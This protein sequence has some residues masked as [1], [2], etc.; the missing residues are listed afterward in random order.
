MSARHRGSDMTK[1]S[2]SVFFALGLLA[3][4]FPATRAAGGADAG[5]LCDRFP[6]TLA[7][8][9]KTEALGPLFYS[10]IEDTRRTW[11]IPPLL[12]RSWDPIT[13]FN[14]VDVGYP[15]LTYRRFGSE[16][17]WQL[18]QLLSFA[19]GSDQQS[20][21][22]R[23]V[24]LFPIYFQQ[25]ST[26]PS[27]DYTALFPLY[28]HLKHRL[29][30]DE[31]FFVMFPCYSRTRKGEVTTEN[32]LYPLFSRSYG[33]AAHG[34]KVWPFTGHEHQAPT[35]RTNGFGDV[36]VV[37]GRD[38]R[39]VLW[40]F[41]LQSE[42]GIGTE[43]LRKQQA[44]LPF[45]SYVRSPQ[46]DST[47]VL[48]PLI[49]HVTDREKNYRAWETP[50][51][52]VVFARGEGKTTSRVWPF[53]SRAQTTNA[54]SEFY[55]WPVYKYNR[56]RAGT[57][58]MSRTRLFFFLF[59]DK[60]EK[61]TET[62]QARTRLD[63]WPFFTRSMDFNGNSRLQVLACLEPFFPASPSIERDYSPLWSI[64][65][66]QNNPGT[67]ATSQSFFWNLYRR[68]TRP[69]QTKTS[70]LFGLF[71]Y[72]SGPEGKRLRLFYIPVLKIQRNL[73]FAP[74]QMK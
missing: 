73:S 31:I 8:G 68:Q 3:L 72:Q 32:Y 20:N 39:F 58:D 30:R 38:S 27:Q 6:L 59:S 57:L 16:Y 23:R 63:F 71:Q 49:T 5:P 42:S 26:D 17:R 53:Y 40:P 70:A 21:I 41:Y 65:V 64:W 12:S 34:W 56:V 52:L 47:T 33:D 7:P 29:F 37:G 67:H 43:N 51:P 45:Y 13:G 69:Q 11:A 15:L 54:E 2:R 36:E 62:G 24:T 50:W 22:T 66:A 44:L 25:R 28:G 61:N 74:A 19:G 1:P 46:Y 48:W 10:E 60:I 14:E 4:M 9:H 55:L 35:T 18:V